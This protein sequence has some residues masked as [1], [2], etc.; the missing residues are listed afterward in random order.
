MIIHEWFSCSTSVEDGDGGTMSSWCGWHTDHGSL[1]GMQMF[2]HE[3]L[4]QIC[5][6]S[7]VF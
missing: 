6:I 4:L 7:L 5:S 3:S 1:T 2:D